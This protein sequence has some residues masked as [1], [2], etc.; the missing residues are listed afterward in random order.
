MGHGRPRRRG[1]LELDAAFHS[2]SIV[3]RRGVPVRRG[4]ESFRLPL[5]A[6]PE[7]VEAD[8]DGWLLHT[9]TTR[10]R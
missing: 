6:V 3:E 10:S 7:A 1:E 8:P 5:P 9:A 2:R 4:E